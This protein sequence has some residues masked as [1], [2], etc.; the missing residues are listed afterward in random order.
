MP[1]IRLHCKMCSNAYNRMQSNLKVWNPTF[2]KVWFSKSY[3]IL[4][5]HICDKEENK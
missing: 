3:S 2:H 1:E 5:S 4:N